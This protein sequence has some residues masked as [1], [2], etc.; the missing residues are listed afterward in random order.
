MFPLKIKDVP[1]HKY[2]S[3]PR[4]VSHSTL[5]YT[6]SMDRTPRLSSLLFTYN[7]LLNVDSSLTNFINSVFYIKP[8]RVNQTLT[9]FV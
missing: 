9:Q 6:T 3:T 5:Y 8:L 2:L 1:K 4:Y 7:S